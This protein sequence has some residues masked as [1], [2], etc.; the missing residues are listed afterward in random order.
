MRSLRALLLSPTPEHTLSSRAAWWAQHKAIAASEPRPFDGAVLGGYA[1]DRLGYAF[2]SG[3]Q[4]ALR[5][6][7]PDLPADRV[8]SMCVTEKGGGHP[9]FI[10]ASLTREGEGYRLSGR[11]RWATLSLDAGL[12]VVLASLGTG[13][14][15]KKQLKLARVRSETKGVTQVPM[16]EPPFIPEIGHDEVRFHEVLVREEDL[17]PGDGYEDYVKRFRTVEDIHVHAALLGYVAR[18]IRANGFPAMWLER[19]IALMTALS[20]LAGED[21]TDVTLH[22]ALAGVLAESRSVLSE[23]ERM[24]AASEAPTHAR[25]ERDKLLFGVAQGTREKR[26]ARAWEAIEATRRAAFGG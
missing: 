4:A 11:K 15:G 23:V 26:L 12:L 14:D 1:A 18:E 20:M 25:W 7:L 13:D 9:R 21:P 16:P 17:L 10:E 8:V 19:V 22:V 24:W 6:L 2:A 5:A 3:Y